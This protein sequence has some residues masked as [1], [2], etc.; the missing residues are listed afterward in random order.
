MPMAMEVPKTV[1]SN[2]VASCFQ[3]FDIC[4][5]LDFKL[6]PVCSLL[7]LQVVTGGGVMVT[8]HPDSGTP[9]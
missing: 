9:A 3:G 7:V 6:I 8:P 4:F 2:R 5:F 1:V